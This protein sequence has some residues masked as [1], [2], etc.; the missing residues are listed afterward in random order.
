[1]EKIELLI[2]GEQRGF[3]I[4]LRMDDDFDDILYK[5]IKNELSIFFDKYKAADIIPKFILPL[6]VDVLMS[7]CALSVVSKHS[8]KIN[9][10]IDE[11]SAIVRD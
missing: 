7:L 1:M 2:I 10:A 6:M 4:K 9:V 5:E 8:E 3:L 11:L